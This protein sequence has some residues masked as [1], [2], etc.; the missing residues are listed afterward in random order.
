MTS[1]E[2]LAFAHYV[3]E[4]VGFSDSNEASLLGLLDGYGLTGPERDDML[5]ELHK[6]GAVKAVHID[7]PLLLDKLPQS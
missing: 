7:S 1:Q 6:I 4:H 2:M 3:R 5:L